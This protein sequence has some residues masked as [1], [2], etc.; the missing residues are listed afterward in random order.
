MWLGKDLQVAQAL[1]SLIAS[2]EWEGRL[3]GYRT[4]EKRLK[5]HRETI[6][7]ALVLLE[8]EGLVSSTVPGKRREILVSVASKATPE[9]RRLLMV[10]PRPIHECSPTLRTVL[11][12]VLQRA[13][14]LEWN[15]VAHHVDFAFPRRSVGTLKRLIADVGATRVLLISPSPAVE[16][17]ADDTEVPC[18]RIG[19]SSAVYRSP[20]IS[21][22]FSSIVCAAAGRLWSL[23]HR[24]LIIPIVS[25]KDELRRNALERSASSW[26]AGIPRVELEAMFPDQGDWLPDVLK[27]FWPKQFARAKPTGAIVKESNEFFSLLSYCHKQGIR[28]PQDLSVI[29]LSGDQACQ[30]LD[31]IPS[32]FEFPVEEICRRAIHWLEQPQ[33]KEQGMALVSATFVPGGTL[34]A[35]PGLD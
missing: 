14:K 34:A 13:E 35:P 24:R 23:G 15:T 33:P 1:R 12:E 4:L 2:G 27:T 31:P 17:W 9:C 32:R 6:E 30:W 18:F 29:L 20:G 7:K 25:G 22:S 11:L 19:G 5:V 10:G 21:V 28:I 26:A 16:K 3:P 8:A